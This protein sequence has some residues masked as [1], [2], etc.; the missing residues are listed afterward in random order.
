MHA[1]VL[2]LSLSLSFTHTHTHTHTHTLVNTRR[3]LSEHVK[4]AARINADDHN[5]DVDDDDDDDE[6]NDGG[7]PYF[8]QQHAPL[9]ELDS[10]S[11]TL[12]YT[13]YWGQNLAN[14]MD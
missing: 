7:D 8:S 9:S 14:E 5:R 4:D 10:L 13:G 1:H 2:S 3:N 12:A 6:A 11:Q